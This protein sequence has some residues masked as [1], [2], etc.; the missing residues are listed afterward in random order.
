MINL[1]I[2]PNPNI[3]K[4]NKMTEAVKQNFGY[5][6]CLVEQSPDTVCICKDFKEQNI[7]G[8]CHCGRYIKVKIEE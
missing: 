1:K 3:D 8:E 5:C 6:P 7:E 4:Y 2:I